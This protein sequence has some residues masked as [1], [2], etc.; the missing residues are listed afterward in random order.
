MGKVTVITI[1]VGELYAR[2]DHGRV[3]FVC[4]DRDT[5]DA[6]ELSLSAL[7]AHGL[8]EVLPGLASE[9]GHAALATA[10]AD[11]AV[12]PLRQQ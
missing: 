1:E 4:Y 5:G 8:A 10:I 6:T 7:A 12:E 9:A 11:L 3:V 2:L